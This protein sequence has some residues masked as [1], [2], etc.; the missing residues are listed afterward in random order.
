LELLRGLPDTFWPRPCKRIRDWREHG[1]TPSSNTGAYNQA[2]QALPRSIV[3]KSCDHIFQQLVAQ[4][5]EPAAEVST[6]AFLLDG[7]SM[8]AAHSP[9]LCESY[10]P[11]SNQHGESHWPLLR[12][13]VAHELHS[14]LAMRPEW[15]PM[16]GS[17]WRRKSVPLSR[18]ETRR[19]CVSSACGFLIF[20]QALFPPWVLRAWISDQSSRLKPVSVGLRSRRRDRRLA[21]CRRRGP[22]KL[23]HSPTATNTFFR[24][25]SEKCN[26][27]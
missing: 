3:Q 2:R 26:G 25:L 22:A 17:R 12:V 11:G 5:G 20:R 15:G 8:R 19:Q 18:G 4:M 27:S 24:F 16:H 6:R 23:V 21:D 14:G 1:R 10:P 13:L 7:S 9:E